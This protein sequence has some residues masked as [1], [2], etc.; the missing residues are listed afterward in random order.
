LKEQFTAHATKT[1]GLRQE[2]RLAALNAALTQDV[3]QP[4]FLLTKVFV[5]PSR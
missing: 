4:P 2:H 3:T 5:L 1:I